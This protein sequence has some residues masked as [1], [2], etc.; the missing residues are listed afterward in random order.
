MWMNLSDKR[1]ELFREVR[2]MYL[3]DSVALENAWGVRGPFWARH[4][5]FW[6]GNRP[7]CVIYEVFSPTLEAYLGERDG[8]RGAAGGA[9]VDAAAAAAV[10]RSSSK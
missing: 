1:T 7:L 6:A 2:R 9:R 8:E 5:I 4:Y 3:G 10:A